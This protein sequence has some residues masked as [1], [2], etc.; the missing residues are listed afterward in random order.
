MVTNNTLF[1]NTLSLAP[2]NNR[3]VF[4]ENFGFKRF[5]FA[6]R[7]LFGPVLTQSFD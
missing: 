7:R 2:L 6:E 3:L 1:E 5:R 4:L